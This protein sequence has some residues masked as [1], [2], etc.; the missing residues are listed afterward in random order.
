MKKL[1]ICIL[2]SLILTG[3]YD[4]KEIDSRAY[5]LAMSVDKKEDGLYSITFQ[6]IAPLNIKTGVETAFDIEEGDSALLNYTVEG[7]SIDFVTEKA[8]DLISK[9]LDLSQLKCIFINKDSLDEPLKKHLSD[10]KKFRD[11]IYV[12]FTESSA[13]K[14]MKNARSP[15]ELNPSKYY[16]TLLSDRFSQYSSSTYLWEILNKENLTV[17]CFKQSSWGISPDGTYLLKKNTPIHKFSRNDTLYLNIVRGNL[18]AINING[19]K[20][21]PERKPFISN[22]LKNK[23][24]IIYIN[25]S[26]EVKD[27]SSIENGIN[28]VVSVMQKNDCDALNLKNSQKKFFSDNKTFEKKSVDIGKMNFS[29]KVL[30]K[31][32]KGFKK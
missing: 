8:D 3:C 9:K 7:E 16:E 32:T 21:V 6:V 15:L 27:T 31:S 17:P 20:T 30:L 26:G 13:E 14:V 22:D 12:V 23:S 18:K 1:L 2:C 19:D 25:L 5:A 4:S 24:A 11:N 29:C 28:K 10:E